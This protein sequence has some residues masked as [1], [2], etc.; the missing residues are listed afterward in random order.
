M[1]GAINCFGAPSRWAV[2]KDARR[3]QRQRQR[4]LLATLAAAVLAT[5]A[6]ISI[7]HRPET[8]RTIEASSLGSVT[9]LD[10]G[11]VVQGTVELGRN[12]W[13][14]TCLKNCDGPWSLHATGQLIEVDGD[15]R[16]IRRFSVTDAAALTAGDGAIWLAHPYS[17]DVSRM[18]PETGRS[19]ASVPLTLPRPVTRA[20]D[21]R[22]FPF[23]VSYSSGRVWASSARGW[24]AEIDPSAARLVRMAYSSSEATSATTAAGVTWIAD[25][26][27]GVGIWTA[28]TNHVAHHVISWAGQTLDIE[29]VSHQAGLIW[30]SG[31]TD[32]LDPS[33][34]DENATVVTTI[35]PQTGRIEHQWRVGTATTMVVADGGAYVDDSQ[36]GELLRLTA[37]DHLQVLHGPRGVDLDAVT[38]HAI[39]ATGRDGRLV[40]IGLRGR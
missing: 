16:A 1:L 34:G 6:V 10:L 13:V 7:E 31:S 5:A 8:V 2:I 36:T 26:L 40:R 25:E 4:R 23:S 9:R 17:G 3:R 39:W 33:P 38:A 30:A 28:G 11:G 19:T 29:A 24:T 12:L 35:N 14:L 32:V 27:D 37:P 15:G 21:R 20:G 18:N 22:F